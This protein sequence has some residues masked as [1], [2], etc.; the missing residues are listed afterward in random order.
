MKC[1]KYLC[2]NHLKK[3][4]N[5]MNKIYYAGPL[6]NDA[7]RDF[8][9]KLVHKLEKEGFEVFL[10]Q[11]DGVEASKAEYVNLGKEKECL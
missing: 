9:I 5:P 3:I 11:R 1:L 8:N 6:F 7:E 4:K 2:E 10:P